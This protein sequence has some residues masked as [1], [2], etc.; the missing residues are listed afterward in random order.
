MNMILSKLFSLFNPL[1]AITIVGVFIFYGLFGIPLFNGF[2]EF[3]KTGDIESFLTVIMSPSWWG[4]LAGF[5]I[6]LINAV[7]ICGFIATILVIRKKIGN[8][9]KKLQSLYLI[10]KNNKKELAELNDILR[11]IDQKIGKQ[12]STSSKIEEIVER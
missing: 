4:G 12:I 5:G 10:E 8:T 6:G 11:S 7:Y 1:L 3:I 2:I 9:D